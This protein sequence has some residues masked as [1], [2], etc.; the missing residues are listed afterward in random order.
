MNRPS[1]LDFV[2]RSDAVFFGVADGVFD[3]FPQFHQLILIV[4]NDA[5]KKRNMD[6][7][8]TG[9]RNRDEIILSATAF[10]I[11]SNRTK[12]IHKI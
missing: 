8:R 10:L 6:D 11:R 12:M 9:R 4:I 7:R 5:T 2:T 1:S 3:D